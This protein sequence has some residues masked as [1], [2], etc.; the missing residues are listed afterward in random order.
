MKL[1]RTCNNVRKAIAETYIQ[2]VFPLGEGRSC[3]DSAY[4]L[5]QYEEEMCDVD[6]EG[7]ACDN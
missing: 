2:F 3:E 5:L 1:Y 6:K 4:A 7:R